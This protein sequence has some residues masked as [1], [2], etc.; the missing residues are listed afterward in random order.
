M[1]NPSPPGNIPP[2]T[3]ERAREPGWLEYFRP[4]R[5]YFID[6]GLRP[7]G[8]PRSRRPADARGGGRRTDGASPG[9]AS[10]CVSLSRHGLLPDHSYTRFFQSL[11][12]GG[13]GEGTAQIQEALDATRRSPF[14]IFSRDIPLT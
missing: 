7:D 12:D 9:R 10:R 5:G 4:A 6:H 2:A 1:L 8:S 11:L 3:A 13:A 14:V